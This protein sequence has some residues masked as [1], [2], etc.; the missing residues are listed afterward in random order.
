M[1]ILG[2]SGLAG[3]KIANQAKNSYSV[4]G[5]FNK[6]TPNIENISTIKLDLSDTSNLKKKIKEIEPDF[7]VN[8]TALHNVDYCEDNKEESFFINSYV[9]QEI[10]NASNQFQSKIIHISTDY[11]FDG[12]SHSPYKETDIATPIS[13]YGESKLAGEKIILSNNH[14]VVRP[15]VVYGWTSLELQGIVSSSGKPVNFA[16]WLLDKLH[17]KEP[18]SIVTDQFAS[19]TLADSI[20]SSILKIISL[21]KSGLYHVSGLSCESRYDFS[22][23]LAKVFGY[24]EN[25]ISKTNS[26]KFKQKAKRPSYSCLDCTKAIKELGAELYKTEEALEIMKKQVESDAPYL[27]R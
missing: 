20:A 3:S 13:V 22:V 16:M 17:K 21:E 25:Q 5:T 7:I 12:Y 11:V 24:D 4:F 15:S 26:S 23:K 27:I 2:V 10:I 14:T 18:L 9:L 1:L 19:A 8:A 6:R